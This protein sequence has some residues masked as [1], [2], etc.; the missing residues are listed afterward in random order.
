MKLRSDVKV[1]PAGKVK[2][3]IFTDIDGSPTFRVYNAAGGFIDYE[4]AHSDLFVVIDDVDAYFYEDKK[5][6]NRLD[7]SPAT[8]GYEHDNKSTAKRR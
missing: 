5:G 7:H 2:G 8:L 1:I 3:C 6:I 4:I